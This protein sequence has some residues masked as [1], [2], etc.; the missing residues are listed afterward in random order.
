MRHFIQDQGVHTG[1]IKEA[2]L[3]SDYE[4][5]A[6][7]YTATQQF[8]SSTN[9]QLQALTKKRRERF[10]NK[11]NGTQKPNIYSNHERMA[12]TTTGIIHKTSL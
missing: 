4:L 3:I 5:K 10:E 2:A 12:E 1:Q 6:K 9:Q 11:A 7:I 8:N